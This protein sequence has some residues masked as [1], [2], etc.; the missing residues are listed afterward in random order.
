MDDILALTFILSHVAPVPENNEA[1]SVAI[2][3]WLFSPLTILL[4]LIF[5]LHLQ[6]ISSSIHTAHFRSCKCGR[7]LLF[8]PS[9]PSLHCS[10]EDLKKR[11]QRRFLPHQVSGKD[12]C[13]GWLD[14]ES[15]PGCQFFWAS[16]LWPL[17][18]TSFSES[19]ILLLLCVI[20]NNRTRGFSSILFLK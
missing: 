18:E 1:D 9:H 3:T 14:H 12:R 17:V 11:S 4:R 15:D 8:S 7:S 5:P 20:G 2:C 19:L 10:K 13:L 16:S 6:L